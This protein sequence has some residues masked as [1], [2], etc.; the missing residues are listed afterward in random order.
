MPVCAKCGHEFDVGRFC[1]NCGHPADVPVDPS[2]VG[3]DLWRS[4][5]ADRADTA[6]RADTGERAD[7]AERPVV[8]AP[9]L[10]P[11]PPDASARY[12]L[13]ADEATTPARQEPVSSHRSERPW[14]AWVAGAVVLVLVA[15]LG[16][17]LLF[18]GDDSDPD[19]VAG[20]PRNTPAEPGPKDKPAKPKKKQTSKPP[21]PGQPTDVANLATATVPA[22]AEPG[23]DFEGNVVR[24][25]ARNMLD[26]VPT[27]CWRMAGDGS[28]QTIAV[29]LD[30]ET[31]LTRVGLINGYAKT[32]TDPSGQTLDWYAGNRRILS[33]EWV[34]DDGSVVSQDLTETRK[35]QSIEIEPVTTSTVELRLVTVTPPGQGPARRDYTAIS[36]LAVV[37][38]PA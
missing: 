19:L 23:V 5:T 26:G 27:T 12:P 17:W 21:A 24:Y 14:L 34:F 33:V 16:A 2:E 32:D 25:E 15:G 18:G 9:P 4:D 13:F 38:K 35:L 6:E 11:V 3:L 22:T 37:G 20:E 8:P 31:E 29:A 7:T 10:P 30:E 28:G 36:D 1:T